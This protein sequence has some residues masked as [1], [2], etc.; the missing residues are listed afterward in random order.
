MQR[1]ERNVACPGGFEPPTCASVVRRS[2]QL[3]YG[4]NMCGAVFGPLRT[5]TR[6]R[7][8]NDPGFSVLTDCSSSFGLLR[9]ERGCVEE[10][11]G[12]PMSVS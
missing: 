4:Q 3:S 1:F 12:G 2:V 11:I 8:W 9:L 10:V 5:H 7:K 6:S